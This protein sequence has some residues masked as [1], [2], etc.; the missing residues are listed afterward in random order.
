[1]IGVAIE[2]RV[3]SHKLE[4][5]VSVLPRPGFM[6]HLKRFM[7]RPLLGSSIHDEPRNRSDQFFHAMDVR[8][9]ETLRPKDS[10]HVRNRYRPQ[11][12]RRQG[13]TVSTCRQIVT[14]SMA[15]RLAGLANQRS[16]R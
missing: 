14:L 13:P 16:R 6:S 10:N 4:F 15:A 1:V 7:E 3:V 11:L 2:N 8:G 5:S 12:F 9:A